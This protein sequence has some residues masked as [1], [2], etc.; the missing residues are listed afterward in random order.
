LLRSRS[1]K[2]LAVRRVTQD[3][4]GKKTAGI[5]GITVVEP[6]DRCRLAEELSLNNPAQPLRRAWIPKPGT[7]EQRPLGIPVIADRATQALAK[8]ALEPQWEAR[9]EANSYGFRPGRSC[10]DALEALFRVIRSKPRAVLDADIAQ[11]FDR[12]DQRALLEK[13]DTFPSLR[14]ALKGW[15]KAGILDGGHFF[16]TEAG[17]PQGG[18]ISPLLANIALHGLEGAVVAAFPRT[19]EVAGKRQNWKPTLIRYA[20]DLVVLHQDAEVIRR[21]QEV[22]ADWLKGMGLELR[23][24]KTFIT[25]TLEVYQG[26]VGFDFLG[27]TVRQFRVGKHHSGKSGQGQRL[28]FKTLIKPSKKK[29]KVHYAR[30][31]RIVRE[32]RGA[33][34]EELIDRLNPV[35]RGWS[36]YYRSVVSKATFARLDHLLHKLLRRWAQRRHPT[37]STT[38]VVARYWRRPSWEF[39]THDQTLYRHAATRIERHVKVRGKQSPYDGDWLYWASRCGHYPGLLPGKAML[40]KEQ[41]GRCAVC[42]RVFL[43]GDD[44]IDRHHRD[45]DRKNNRRTNFELLHRHCHDTV[46]RQQRATKP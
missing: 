37:K 16:P 32:M 29:A 7:A 19:R 33:T 6:E 3:N 8:L 18:V 28:G 41:G 23:P 17:T 9:F 12:I 39:G 24:S 1:A 2:L 15:L 21:C 25:H 11:C 43:P 44:V 4:Q 30:L 34:Q 35:I 36:N 10:H 38:W 46:H 40:L 22:I 5:D 14:R 27:F 45:G 26:R 31:K 13:I 20:D 42:G